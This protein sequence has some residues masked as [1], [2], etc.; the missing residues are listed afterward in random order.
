MV[1]EE[2]QPLFDECERYHKLDAPGL[3]AAYCQG[4]ILGIYRYLRESKSEFRQ[5]SIDAPGECAALLLDAWRD[6]NKETARIDAMRD[7][8]RQRCPE[9]A[10]WIPENKGE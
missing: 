2:F 6:R 4:V 5:W 8:I 9:W 3:E 7:F 1:E 10:G